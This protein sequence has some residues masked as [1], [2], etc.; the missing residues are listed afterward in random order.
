MQ[1]GFTTAS[2]MKAVAALALT[3]AVVLTAF[4]VCARWWERRSLAG[5]YHLIDPSSCRGDLKDSILVVRRDGTYDQH[6]DLKTGEKETAENEHWAYDR[7]R[8]RITFSKFLI[9]TET[10][11]PKHP[12]LWRSA[13]PQ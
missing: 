7:A 3:I 1:K 4:S 9:S 11:L 12:F 13:T 6:V 10:S 8:R 2:L 5:T